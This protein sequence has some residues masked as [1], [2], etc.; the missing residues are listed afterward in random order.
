MNS[1]LVVAGK[2]LVDIRRNRFLA[3][4]LGFLVVAVTLS[5]V[6]AASAFR[7]SFAEYT[8]YVD[9]LHRA[10]SSVVPAAP[11][12]FAL[13]L[14]RG[15]LEYVEL[16][17][18]LFAIVMGYGVVAKERQRATA[19]L[20]FSRPLGRFTVGGGKILALAAAWLFAVAVIFVVIAGVL[21]VVGNAPLQPADLGRLAL[22]AAVSWVYLLLW[23]CVAM[24]LA[25]L[26]SKL[27][28][29]LV[30]ALVLW[31][32][33][34]LILPQIGDTMDPDNQ[35]PGGL[36]K[37][38]QIAK[39]DETAV[40]SHFAGF[41]AVRNGLEVSS[42]TK[43]FERAVFSYTGIKEIY[44]QQPLGQVWMATAVNFFALMATAG[45]AIAF[46]VRSTTRNTFLR[47]KS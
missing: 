19:A 38:L 16:I 40:L 45:A 5:T 9:A 43:H 8:A 24:G 7:V 28:T 2:E 31:L 41:D 37:S 30:I 35:V 42:V 25:S 15:G 12:L 21:L 34:V 23:S 44:N 1:L 3:L 46:A 11:Q 18:A 20:L 36:F 4:L 17:G 39:A 6:V 27:S 10:G 26:S 29:G 22:V 32:L 33:V 47:R 14:T 13:Q